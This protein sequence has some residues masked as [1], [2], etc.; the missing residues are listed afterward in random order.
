[1][2]IKAK[3]TIK[4]TKGK[5]ASKEVE[6]KLGGTVYEVT[7]ARG[8]K[9]IDKGLATQTDAPQDDDLNETKQTKQTKGNKSKQEQKKDN[10]S[11]TD[12]KIIEQAKALGLDVEGK[13]ADELKGEMSGQ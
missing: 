3:F 4:E 12:D 13:T 2:W 8:K 10:T 11:P 5:G 1:M 9:L 7:D 6:Y